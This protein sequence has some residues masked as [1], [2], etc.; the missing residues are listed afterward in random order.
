MGTRWAI[1]RSGENAVYWWAGS[2]S[3]RVDEATLYGR[4]SEAATI[5]EGTT[6]FAGEHELI[7]LVPDDELM[8]EAVMPGAGLACDWMDDVNQ[9]LGWG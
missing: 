7:E 9:A 8:V 4:K 5:A 3:T 1:R 6:L 2:W